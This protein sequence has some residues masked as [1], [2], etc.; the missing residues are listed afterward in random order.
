MAF[1]AGAGAGWTATAKHSGAATRSAVRA[2]GVKRVRRF[3]SVRVLP[4]KTAQVRCQ[5]AVEK[6][7]P[8][9]EDEELKL[10]SDSAY[11]A[12]LLGVCL[13]A[14]AAVTALGFKPPLPLLIPPLLS[15]AT[16]AKKPR[17]TLKDM[18]SRS[19]MNT[20]LVTP[21]GFS[22]NC[23]PGPRKAAP[24]YAVDKYTLKQR[25]FKAIRA[26]TQRTVLAFRDTDTMTYGLV[27]RS[28]LLQ[29]PDLITVQFVDQG[30]GKSSLAIYS[31]SIYGA[32]DF[33]VN[34]KRVDA[35]LEALDLEMKVGTI[36]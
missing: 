19:S 27:Q 10:K 13:G 6:S 35:W 14:T 15:S 8:G 30:D 16:L 21:P 17:M 9:E 32:G 2:V 5:A 7:A 31:G 18:Q 26:S 22:I 23:S 11:V 33:G 24:V 1:V 20:D 36:A 12:Q 3:H 28:K 25:F 4:T 29:W 34:A